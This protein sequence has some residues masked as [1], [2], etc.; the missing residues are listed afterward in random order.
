MELC[1]EYKNKKSESKKNQLKE[2][3]FKN[4]SIYQL[5]P[6]CKEL[7]YGFSVLRKGYI[8]FIDTTEEKCIT[9]LKLKY[10]DIKSIY[11]DSIIVEIIMNNG[12]L[13]YMKEL[14]F[15][16]DEILNDFKNEH[17]VISD[18]KGLYIMKKC[19]IERDYENDSID[20]IGKSLNEE[21]NEF[22]YKINCNNIE[23]IRE[24]YCGKDDYRDVEIK[25]SD[26]YIMIW[27]E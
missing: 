16:L 7:N 5:E 26:D 21:L 23:K 15:N 17:I 22:T 9:I 13:Y 10:E 4:F 25:T 20:I 14:R 18:N 27:E 3:N 24:N 1:K 11:I 19:K 6:K 2:I 8:E 12:D